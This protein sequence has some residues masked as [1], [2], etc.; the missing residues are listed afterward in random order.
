[1]TAPAPHT[2]LARL[3]AYLR[4]AA[5][6]GRPLPSID[7]ITSALGCHHHH[8]AA[9]VMMR[10]RK[11]GLI[12]VSYGRCGIAAIAAPDGAWILRRDD[13]RVGRPAPRRCLSCREPFSPPHRHRFLCDPCRR[14]N[15]CEVE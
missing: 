3:V 7:Q 8:N 13:R 12:E 10:A 5:A 4:E 6:N 15:G 14:E 1:M 2:Q 11:M 9:K